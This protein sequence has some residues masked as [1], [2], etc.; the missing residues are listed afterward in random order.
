M[1][2]K[3][4]LRGHEIEHNGK[5]WVYCDTKEP[6]VTTHGNR[7]CGHC[8]EFATE[9][10]HDACI[11]DLPGVMNACCGHGHDKAYAQF[12]NGK[13]IQGRFVE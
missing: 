5:E 10:G 12:E 1:T 13:I 3:S 7:P 2:A 11:A 9:K 4:Y 8:G 6:T